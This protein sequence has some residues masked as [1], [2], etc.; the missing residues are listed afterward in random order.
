MDRGGGYRKGGFSQLAFRSQASFLLVYGPHPQKFL[1]GLSRLV[2]M[3]SRPD[4]MARGHDILRQL[5][6]WSSVFPDLSSIMRR[7]TK[8][9]PSRSIC[10]SCLSSLQHQRLAS[11]ASSAALNQEP[12][13]ANHVDSPPLPS[14]PPST[15]PTYQI[16]AAVILSRPPALTRDLTPFEKAYFL[17]QKRLNERLVLPFSRYFYYQRGSPGEINWKR[18]IKERQTPARDIGVY[19]AYSKEGWNDEVLLGAKESEPEE[20]VDALVREAQIEAELSE[21]GEGMNKKE[22]KVE[23]PMP[24]VTEA[25]KAADTKSLNRALTRTLYLVVK[26]GKDGKDG[27]RWGFPSSVL[28]GRESLHTVGIRTSK[29]Q[30]ILLIRFIT[31]SRACIGAIFRPKYEY[32]GNWQCSNWP[33]GHPIPW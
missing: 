18:Q 30:R 31:G 21:E 2:L 7:L 14:S 3:C 11:T 13:S 9:G 22:E 10:K 5:A 33:P 26:S 29:M 1:N 4:F 19:N 25:D 28:K 27:G 12:L 23:K 8:S 24:R 32:V 20:Y 15:Q 17:Y 6:V 16:Q